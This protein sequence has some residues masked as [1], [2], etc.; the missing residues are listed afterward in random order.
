MDH[1]LYS[2][3]PSKP[4][5]YLFKNNTG[6]LIYVGKAKDLKKRVSSYFSK[7]AH[8]QK[9]TLLVAQIHKVDHI[10]VNSE[11][12]AFLLEA[13]LIKEHLPYFN[14]KMID[15]KSYPYIMVSDSEIPYVAI[16]RKKTSKNAVYFG[17]Y[18]DAGSVKVVL[19]LLR[20]IF[21]YESVSFWY[22]INK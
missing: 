4:G 19:K 5:V 10:V 9:T 17:P 2:H 11:I 18:P 14:I 12:E 13:E 8:D 15:D 7:T 21:P 16:S 3:L 22:K 1:S 20:K 6:G